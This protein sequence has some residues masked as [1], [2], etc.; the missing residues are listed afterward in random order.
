MTRPAKRLPKQNEEQVRALA[1]FLHSEGKRPHEIAEAV[2]DLWPGCTAYQIAKF[3]G[4]PVSRN[5]YIHAM[6]RKPW[7]PMT[8][9]KPDFVSM[10]KARRGS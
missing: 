9:P 8:D 6:E 5:G 7:N 2:R 3:M 4:L 1:E 10:M